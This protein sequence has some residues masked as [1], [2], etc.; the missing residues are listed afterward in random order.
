MSDYAQTFALYNFGEA[1]ALDVNFFPFTNGAIDLQMGLFY[2]SQVQFDIALEFEQTQND[3]MTL[4]EFIFAG[5]T[6]RCK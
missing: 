4:T 5:K 2:D 6:S 3:S 1:R